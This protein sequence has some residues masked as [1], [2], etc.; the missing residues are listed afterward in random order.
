M[1]SNVLQVELSLPMLINVAG[2][3]CQS[4]NGP[5]G[6]H[7]SYQNEMKHG[8]AVGGE[9]YVETKNSERRSKDQET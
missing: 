5:L 7:S 2:E 8:L 9:K 1:L 6:P 3:R 4:I